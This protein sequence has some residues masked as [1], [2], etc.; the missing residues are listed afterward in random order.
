MS[1]YRIAKKLFQSVGSDIVI[2]EVLFEIGKDVLL[3]YVGEGSIYFCGVGGE[4]DRDGDG[5]KWAFDASFVT[6]MVKTR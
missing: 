3:E 5:E 1:A 2:P 4:G 6:E